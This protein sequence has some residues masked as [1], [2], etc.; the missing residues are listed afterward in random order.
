M[1]QYDEAKIIPNSK[2]TLFWPF[3]FYNHVWTRLKPRK[4]KGSSKTPPDP[5]PTSKIPKLKLR[6]PPLSTATVQIS[7]ESPT[8]PTIQ[9]PSV[10]PTQGQ[11][12]QNSQDTDIYIPDP[13]PSPR[14]LMIDQFREDE[15][16]AAMEA[17]EVSASE[18]KLATSHPQNV[19]ATPPS[20]LSGAKR[21]MLTGGLDHVTSDAVN[22]DG[23]ASDDGFPSDSDN[24]ISTQHKRAKIRDEPIEVEDSDELEGLDRTVTKTKQHR[25]KK[26]SL[27]DEEDEIN[28]YKNSKTNLFDIYRFYLSFHSLCSFH[29]L[30]SWKCTAY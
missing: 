6:I 26:N 30:C 8:T 16:R 7:P 5:T 28:S 11:V 29:T 14:Q 12:M 17:K 24:I 15:E 21:K 25:K 4:H 1:K 10:L 27:A 2:I 13:Y 19:K 23:S 18:P 22:H 9:A 20:V 3:S